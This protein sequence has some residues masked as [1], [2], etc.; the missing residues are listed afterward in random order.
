MPLRAIVVLTLGGLFALVGAMMATSRL[1][2]RIGIGMRSTS[3]RASDAAWEAGHRAVA[4]PLIV[5][6]IANLALGVWMFVGYGHSSATDNAITGTRAAVSY[7]AILAL[8]LMVL[9][10]IADFRARVVVETDAASRDDQPG[11]DSPS[12]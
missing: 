7:V 5:F 1:P 3:M 11:H 8:V 6:G 4:I 9:S 2:R 12:Q 10:S